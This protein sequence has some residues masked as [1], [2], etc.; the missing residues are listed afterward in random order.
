MVDQSPPRKVLVV[1]DDF[2]VAEIHRRFVDATPGFRTVRIVHTAADAVAAVRELEPD[3][4]LLDVY[5]PDTSGLTALQQLRGEG[6][7]VAVIVVTAALELDAVGKALHGGA[8]DY[9]VKPFEYPQLV[10]KLD[11]YLR[12]ARALADPTTMDQ[13]TIDSLF[14]VARPAEPVV[15]PKGLSQETGQLVLEA[16]RNGREVS[17]TECA[18]L[19]GLS[20]VSA[21][22]YLEYYSS[23]GVLTVR[24]EYGRAGRPV[25][26]YRTTTQP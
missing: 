10:E 8:S 4:V 25:H 26:R 22:R 3:L 24:L 5:L 21:R 17:A 2:M 12:R 20:R 9:L 15:L 23:V 13:S 1:D 16:V 7:D 14:G 18:E 19:A 11:N 6:Y